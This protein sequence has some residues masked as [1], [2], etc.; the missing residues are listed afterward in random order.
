V[1]G[2]IAAGLRNRE[3]CPRPFDSGETVR[4]G[5]SSVPKKPRMIDRVQDIILAHD[6]G[7]GAEP[8]G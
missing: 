1:L 3:S 4:N 8:E 6:A 7:M 5:I 2:L